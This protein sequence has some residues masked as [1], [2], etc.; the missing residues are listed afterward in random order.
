MSTPSEV[1]EF[2][3]GPPDQLPAARPEWFRKDAAFDALI[4]E[5]FGA[6]VDRALEGGIEGWLASPS[7]SLARILVLDQ[8]TRNRHRDTPRAFAGDALALAGARALVASGWH[9]GFGPLQRMFCYLP[10]EH[11]ESLADQEES[12]RLFGPLRDEPLLPTVYDYAVRHHDIIRQFGR[13]PHRNEIL[14]RVSSAAER[15]FLAQPGS[16]F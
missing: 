2:W 6:L 1:L 10:F 8:F 4:D 12:L 14:G 5:R 9:L 3:F 13:F 16:R 11:S 15:E 7:A